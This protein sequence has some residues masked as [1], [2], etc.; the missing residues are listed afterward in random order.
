MRPEFVELRNNPEVSVLII[1]GGINGI[2]LFNE[3]ALQGVDVLLA[4][5]ENPRAVNLPSLAAHPALEPILFLQSFY[6]MAES[7]SRARGLNP[8]QPPHLNKVTETL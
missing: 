3:L 4:G 1:G 6:R 7:L 8:D 2:G 5:F